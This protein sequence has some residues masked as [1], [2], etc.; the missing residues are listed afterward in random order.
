MSHQVFEAEIYLDKSTIKK[1]YLVGAI[2]LLL[3]VGCIFWATFNWDAYTEVRYSL[4]YGTNVERGLAPTLYGW[5][6]GFAIAIP[7]IYGLMWMSFD[8]KNPS[9]AVNKS[10]IFIN[11]ELFKQTFMEWDEFEKM[12]KDSEGNISLFPKDP[13]KM[14]AQQPV[15]R[16]P[17]L[18]QT[19]VKDKSPISLE[20]DERTE[21]IVELAEQYWRGGSGM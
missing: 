7:I 5:G 8:F 4:K 16:R 13:K 3:S 17:F 11:R 14:V 12:E 1:V 6:W 9:L 18:K 21:Q 10:G 19:F 15:W 2:L 20:K